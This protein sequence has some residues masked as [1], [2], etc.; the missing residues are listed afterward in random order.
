MGIELVVQGTMNSSKAAYVKFDLS[1]SEL[2]RFPELHK[3]AESHLAARTSLIVW[4]ENLTSLSGNQGILV[5]S[6]GDY[7]AM[8][9]P[10]VEGEELWIVAKGLKTA[11]E[12][13][14]SLTRPCDIVLTFKAEKIHSL[15]AVNPLVDQENP[16]LAGKNQL[17]G[18]GIEYVHLERTNYG[19]KSEVEIIKKLRDNGN[20]VLIKAE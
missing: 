4:T 9:V 2:S 11:F 10:S 17:K 7:V 19:T 1:D 20:L 13:A 6:N 5:Y 16:I 8:K 15:K 14:L 3:A 18:A 12:K